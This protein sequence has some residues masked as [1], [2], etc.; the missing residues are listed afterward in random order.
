MATMQF[1]CIAIVNQSS[2]KENSMDNTK[3]MHNIAHKYIELVDGKIV[4]TDNDQLMK[5]LFNEVGTTLEE[6]DRCQSN[7]STVSEAVAEVVNVL[8]SEHMADNPECNE[9]TVSIEIAGQ[10]LNIKTERTPG[11]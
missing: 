2:F 4:V 3:T 11:A 7:I 10:W 1:G 5:E 9:H 6:I 8:S